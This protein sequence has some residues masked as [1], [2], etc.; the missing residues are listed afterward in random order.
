MGFAKLIRIYLI[1]MI[2]ASSVF[3]DDPEQLE[4][5]IP[6]SANILEAVKNCPTRALINDE[7]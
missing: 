7:S 4:R 3:F 5:E 6:S 1:T 2:M